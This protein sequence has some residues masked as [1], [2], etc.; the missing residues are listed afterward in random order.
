VRRHA[1]ADGGDNAAQPRALA[2]DTRIGDLIE[3][4]ENVASP[5]QTSPENVAPPN[6]AGPENIAKSNRAVP[7]NVAPAKS[8]SSQVRG[9]EVEIACGPAIFVIAQVIGDDSHDCRADL[10]VVLTVF[11]VLLL[12]T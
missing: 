10:F 7:R 6:V 9:A 12:L 8:T 11:E 3:S 5:N 4:P 1:V 2:D